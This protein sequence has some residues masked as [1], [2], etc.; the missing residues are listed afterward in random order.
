VV[1]EQMMKVAQNATDY[2][3]ITNLYKKVG[4]LFK[5]ALGLSPSA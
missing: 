1:E 4:N 3:M 2:Q 5:E